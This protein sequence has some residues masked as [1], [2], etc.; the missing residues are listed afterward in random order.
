ML[1]N[2]KVL[3]TYSIQYIWGVVSNKASNVT[4]G[5][6]QET[7]KNSSFLWILRDYAYHSL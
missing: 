5:N 4:M 3:D 2:P 6:Q 7:K 1:E